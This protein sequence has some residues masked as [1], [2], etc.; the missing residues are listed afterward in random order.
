MEQRVDY[1]KKSQDFS[2]EYAADI[3]RILKIPLMIINFILKLF[4]PVAIIHNIFDNNKF[5]K[6]YNIIATYNHDLSPKG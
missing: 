6:L 2:Q 5:K 4:L 1:V 3:V